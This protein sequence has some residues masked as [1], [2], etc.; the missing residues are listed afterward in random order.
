M[1]IIEPWGT[2]KCGKWNKKCQ[3]RDPERQERGRGKAQKAALRGVPHP[4]HSN[5]MLTHAGPPGTCP[6]SEQEISA[7]SSFL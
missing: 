1:W 3:D 4:S 2:L 6:F 5:E 7:P